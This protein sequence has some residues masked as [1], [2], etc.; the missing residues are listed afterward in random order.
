MNE[1][2]PIAS[3][4]RTSSS[5]MLTALQNLEQMFQVCRLCTNQVA[6]DSVLMGMALEAQTLALK[7]KTML[8]RWNRYLPFHEVMDVKFDHWG[9]KVGE[10][11]E[12][13]EP[14]PSEEM[15]AVTRALL[16]CGA[17][18][19]E[20]NTIRKRFSGVKGGKFARHIAPARVFSVILSDV[21]GDPM[22]MIASGPAYP[23]SATS[24]DSIAIAKK[25]SLPLSEAAWRLLQEETPKELPGVE[26]YVTGSV[27]VLCDAAEKVC[28]E[29]GYETVLLTDTLNCE[30]RDAG[31]WFASLAREN[32]GKGQ[33]AFLAGGET[34]VKLKGNGLGG[35]NQEM[36]LAAAIGMEGLENV[37]FFSLGSDGTD[38]PTDAAGGWADGSTVHEI[39]KNGF[40]PSD[41]LE[42]N[43]AYHALIGSGNLLFTG[44]TGTNVNDISVLLIGE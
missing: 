16:G 6:S 5:D 37:L 33:K 41:A 23:D 31:A 1:I 20:I 3:G 7:M 28:R 14:A 30:A 36:A 22:D 13:L 17:D 25:Y 2:E 32:A 12:A 42:N 43:D 26:S 9:Q 8:A 15:E 39:Q 35:R 38:G 44:P 10:W 4:Q 34:V 18:I 24:E 27:K 11:I 29:L 21:L 19:T 40:S